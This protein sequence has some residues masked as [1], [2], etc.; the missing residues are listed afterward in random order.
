MSEAAEIS[1]AVAQVI[2]RPNFSIPGDFKARTFSAC[3]GGF[4]S[5]EKIVGSL[6]EVRDR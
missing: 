1:I 6:Q 5:L 2:S 3:I 4:P